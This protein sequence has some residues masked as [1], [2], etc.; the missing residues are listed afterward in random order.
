MSQDTFGAIFT[1]LVSLASHQGY[2]TF[3]NILDVAE[4]LNL[5]VKDTDKLT[6][7]LIKYGILLL[8]KTPDKHDVVNEEA[9]FNDYAQI[10]YESVFKRVVRL[11]PTLA[12]FV[13][14][15]K[16]IKPP[17]SGE[18][19]RLIFQA[20]EGNEYARKRIAEM[21]IRI[22]VRLGFQK[23]LQYDVAVDDCIEDAMI[24]LMTAIDQFNPGTGTPFVGST[25]YRIL[26][27]ILRGITKQPLVRYPAQHKEQFLK[28]YP[29]LKE[30]GCLG[31]IK[32]LDCTKIR[33]HLLT[34]FGFESNSI[35]NIIAQAVPFKSLEYLNSVFFN[36]GSSDEYEISYMDEEDNPESSNCDKNRSVCECTDFNYMILHDNPL[37]PLISQERIRLVRNILEILNHRERKIICLRYGISC[38]H[39][40]T[41]EEIGSIFKISR[42]RVRQIIK[43]ILL[44]LHRHL[45]IN[46]VY[47]EDYL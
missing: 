16:S 19:S 3:D 39:E 9:D 20:K 6:N 27:A 22:A 46:E 24:G 14:R 8:E 31:C 36:D 7:S 17:Q 12:T 28:A 41:F 44:K 32:L 43:R 11:D 45:Q 10:D 35:E 34:D 2:I 4:R 29:I 47:A 15:V 23:A 37:L 18:R 25:N 5:P 26:S 38:K 1:S 40:H 13:N 33:E 30:K 42:E 21:H